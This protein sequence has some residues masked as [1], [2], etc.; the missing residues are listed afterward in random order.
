MHRLQNAFIHRC[1]KIKEG[2]IVLQSGYVSFI[3][4]VAEICV[5]WGGVLVGIHTE[6]CCIVRSSRCWSLLLLSLRKTKASRTTSYVPP[7]HPFSA[8]PPTATP[9]EKERESRTI[10]RAHV[11]GPF[12]LTTHLNKPFSELD[13]L[14]KWNLVYFGFT[15]CPDICP[16]ELDKVGVVVDA[17]G[18][19]FLSSFW[20][21][22]MYN[23]CWV[24]R[25]RTRGDLP[26]TLHIRRP[27]TRHPRTSNPLPKRFSSTPNRTHR[28][29]HHH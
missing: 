5:Y 1:R 13:L 3:F 12:T 16:A 17:L 28:G 8:L 19:F 22:A 14:G 18:Q 4:N 9:T 6:S 21:D 29:L 15:N 26:T 23:V 11:G 27:S 2:R 20:P 7:P 24:N 10:G 25:K